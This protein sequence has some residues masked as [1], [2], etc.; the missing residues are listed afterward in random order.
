MRN[1][2]WPRIIGQAERGRAVLWHNRLPF[3]LKLGAAFS[4]RL[5]VVP[6]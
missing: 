4:L 3:I 1:E 5:V 6:Q 2:V